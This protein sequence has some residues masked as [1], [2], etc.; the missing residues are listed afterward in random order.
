LA[1]LAQAPAPPESTVRVRVLQRL[2]P[3]AAVLV[4]PSRFAFEARG[5]SLHVD[6]RPVQ[7]PFRVEEAAW[8]LLLQG[9]APRHYTGA[10]S[11]RAV[12]GELAFVL[13]LPLE[14]YVAS[15]VAAETTPGTPTQALEAQAVVARSFV[16]AQPPRHADADACD[17]T[18]C[19]LLRGR[20]VPGAHQ[21]RARAAALAT[22]GRVL[23]LPSGAVAET[24]FHAAC[25]GH[26]A[27]PEEV[28][29]SLSTGAASVPDTGCEPRH[30]EV[31]VPR[32]RFLAA[33]DAV[34]S[35]PT[36]ADAQAGPEAGTLSLL[37]GR[38]GYVVRVV[39]EAGRSARGDAVA[40]ALDRAMG[41]GAVRSGRFSFRPEGDTVRVS[42][43]GLGHGLGLCQAGAAWRA[44]RGEDYQ[45]ILRHYFPLASLR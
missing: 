31:A 26:T 9:E 10:F 14:R 40:R 22:A 39:T 16:L 7:Q 43:A 1:L 36:A 29:G 17:L 33:L 37:S 2:H 25:G 38:G 4:G 30:W 23:V 34:L 12:D 32:E 13:R 27:E 24:P 20:G 3:T 44:A 8:R 21:A 6:G 35:G 5:A 11:V 42:G 15:V 18:H 41:W 19:Q 45:A 28:L